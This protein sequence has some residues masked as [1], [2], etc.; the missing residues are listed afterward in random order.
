V[1]EG[2]L[3]LVEIG[4]VRQW[5]RPLPGSSQQLLAISAGKS[6]LLLLM[7][8]MLLLLPLLLPLL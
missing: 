1:D 6:S 5:P 2:V 4:R 8:L 3:F 7:L